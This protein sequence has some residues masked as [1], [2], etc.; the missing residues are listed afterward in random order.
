MMQIKFNMTQVK[1]PI[2][3]FLEEWNLD[4]PYLN[5]IWKTK[6][7]KITKKIVHLL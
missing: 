1:L 7:A 2:R 3:F 4:K 5:F 6:Q